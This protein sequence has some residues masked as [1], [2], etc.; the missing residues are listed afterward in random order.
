MDRSGLLAVFILSSV[1]L[2]EGDPSS[3][4]SIIFCYK[5][6]QHCQENESNVPRCI[7]KQMRNCRFSL[8]R[9]KNPDF[10]LQ[11][12]NSSHEVTVDTVY[13]HAIHIPSEAV[14]KSSG[15]QLGNGH[16]LH[17]TVSVLN[18]SLF[19]ARSDE[20]SP[21]EQVLGVWLG[22]QDVHNLSH[23]VRMVFVN[24]HQKGRGKCVFWKLLTNSE[25]GS[26]STDGCNTI[27][28]NT[29]FICE[30]SHLS[31][32]AVLISPD[33]PDPV[34]VQRLEHISYIGSSLSVVFTVIIIVMY[35]WQK[36]PKAG[37]T[38]I[39]HI[40]L[41][42]SLFLLHLFFLASSIWSSAEWASCWTLGFILHWALLATFTWMAIEGFHLYLLLVRVFNI[43]ISRYRLKL[44]LVGWGVPTATVV[45]C[46]MAG[47]YGKYT[48][49]ENA[50][51]TTSLCWVT[52]KATRYITVNGYL[53]LLLLFNAVI[54]AVMVVKMRQLRAR[55]IQAGNRVRRMWKDWASL[56]GLSCVLGLPWGLAFI[57]HGPQSVSLS[58]VYLFTVLN[59]FQGVLMFLWFLSITWKSFHDEQH[60]TKGSSMSNVT[61]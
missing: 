43:C 18:R 14:L 49:M 7:E 3:S 37:Q 33:V 36:N 17:L 45:I 53:G 54:L 61:S 26:W 56:L 12:V 60:S 5:V 57:T 40:Q 28:N 38:L 47:A 34:D 42:G 59:A 29:D 48:L 19:E 20:G 32:F 8:P 25:Q 21:H 52:T 4:G 58:A 13:G 23:P 39:I 44:S 31:F 30:C 10:Y 22:K 16:E 50:S 1:A 24:V 11:T 51:R 41:T 55:K 2:T 15:E 35:L 6:P 9:T 27:Q 46:G